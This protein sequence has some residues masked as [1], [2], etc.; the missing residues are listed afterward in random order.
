MN[1]SLILNYYFL[2]GWKNAD[3]ILNNEYLENTLGTKNKPLI[4]NQSFQKLLPFIFILKVYLEL[5]NN[6]LT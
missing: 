5:I 1:Y 6:A 4:K 2:I 3:N